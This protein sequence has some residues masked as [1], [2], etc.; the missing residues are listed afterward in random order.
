[1][2]VCTSEDVEK[3]RYRARGRANRPVVRSRAPDHGAALVCLCRDV[4]YLHLFKQE[5]RAML[6]LNLIYI[7]I[8]DMQGRL[9]ALRGY[10]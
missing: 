9:D 4:P 3:A 2:R 8:K 7:Q 6:E 1:M 5:A 10:L